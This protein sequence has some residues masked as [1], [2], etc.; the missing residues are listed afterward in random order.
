MRILVAHASRMGGTA[1]IAERV[2]QRLREAGF[3]VDVRTCADGAGSRLVRRRCRR[4]RALHPPVGANGGRV[5]Q[6]NAIDLAQKPTWLFQSGPCGEGAEDQPVDASLKVRRL[7]RRI[8]ASTPV[9]FGGR[10]DPTKA[11]TRIQRWMTTGSEAGDWR[12][13]GRIDRWAAEIAE[14]LLARASHPSADHV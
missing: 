7:A 10:L 5:S 12:D 4:Q 6:G 13:W 14:Q 2:G 1:E 3:E 8:G 9:T 11:V